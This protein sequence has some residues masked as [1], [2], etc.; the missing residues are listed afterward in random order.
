MDAEGF[1]I[2]CAVDLLRD[3]KLDYD[4]VTNILMQCLPSF[5][6]L[7]AFKVDSL[8]EKFKRDNVTPPDTF[9]DFMT[10][11]IRHNG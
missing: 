11:T 2:Y 10:P 6:S 8:F 4:Y 1:Y 3:F 9:L 5:T 7:D